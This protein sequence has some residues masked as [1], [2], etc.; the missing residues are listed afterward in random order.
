MTGVP[1]ERRSLTAKFVSYCRLAKLDAYHQL[2]GWLLAVLLLRKDALL[3]PRADLALALVLVTTFGIKCASC[4]AD[5]IMG[6]RNGGDAM[7][8]RTLEYRPPSRKP[9]LT[10][11]LSESEAV[12][13]TVVMTLIGLAAGF[14]ALFVLDWDVPVGVVILFAIMSAVAVQ[15]SYG[16]KLSYHP[17]GLELVVFSV[18]ACTVL[19]PYWLIAD[20]V[21]SNAI[22]LSLLMGVWLVLVVSYANLP[23]REGDAAV[24]RRTI[25]VIAS[26]RT[27]DALLGVLCVLAVVFAIW[28]FARGT[29][30]APALLCVVPVLV[31]NV[32]Q[33]YVGVIRKEALRARMIGFYAIDV[34]SIG[35]AAAILLSG[36]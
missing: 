26:P 7:N 20:G 5:D 34:G 25:A 8:Y 3:T 13:F 22:T 1:T 36:R 12:S 33:F 24:G 30:S 21:S 14:G 15:Y 17:G 2:Y 35:F 11:M 31:M 6:F 29:L 19:L 16:L 32:V 10:G 18:S 27:V 23:D 28:P 4:A 9:L